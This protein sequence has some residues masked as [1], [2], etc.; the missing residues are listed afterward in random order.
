MAHVIVV[1]AG[2]GGIPAAFEL[3]K[4]LGKAHRVTL[5]GARP[6]FEFTPSNPW[7]AVGW[8]S[9]EKTRVLMSEPLKKKGIDW[10]VGEV[11]AID[12][13]KSSLTLTDGQSV[14]YDY[15]II[16]TVPKLAFED[17]PGL[18]PNGFSRSVCTHGHAL[19]AW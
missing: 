7:I 10:L 11:K 4:R 12:A 1:G 19:V 9:A 16:A 2:R 8:R 17:V 14:T 18:G 15:L 5:I 6:H 3:R 13:P